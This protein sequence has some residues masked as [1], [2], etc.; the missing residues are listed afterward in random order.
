MMR[1]GFSD[2]DVEVEIEFTEAERALLVNLLREKADLYSD[3]REWSGQLLDIADTIEEGTEHDELTERD[4][5]EVACA[6]D[7][8]DLSPLQQ[9]LREKVYEALDDA[10]INY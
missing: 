6:L 2:P 5:A 1:G 4:W 8:T 7:G 10:G 9:V 3:D